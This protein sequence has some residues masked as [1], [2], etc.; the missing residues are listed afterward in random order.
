[1]VHKGS[2]N[3][4]WVKSC[5]NVSKIVH[6]KQICLGIIS[7]SFLVG[8]WNKKPTC[9]IGNMSRYP[10]EA[11][12]QFYFNP[13][14]PY[15]TLV[16]E[17]VS[18]ECPL[19]GKFEEIKDFQ[20]LGSWTEVVDPMNNP[21]QTSQI[22]VLS[23]LKKTVCIQYEKS[24]STLDVRI[25][26]TGCGN[27]PQTQVTVRHEGPC[28][29]ALIDSSSISKSSHIVFRGFIYP[30][31]ILSLLILYLPSGI[32]AGKTAVAPTSSLSLTPTAPLKKKNHIIKRQMAGAGPAVLEDEKPQRQAGLE[33][34]FK[35]LQHQQHVRSMPPILLPSTYAT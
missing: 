5:L 29:D 12:S 14:T 32:T 13:Q 10:T 20:C 25:Y 1:M 31:Y 6:S 16:A 30:C 18:M 28:H 17:H 2:H 7:K 33:A 9:K 27:G 3:P 19:Q 35:A 26:G 34:A 23:S 24:E 8:T 22:L 11:C 15:Q 21:N 4:I